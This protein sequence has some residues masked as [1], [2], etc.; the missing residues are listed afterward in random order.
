[1]SLI[2]RVFKKMMEQEVAVV[3]L[4]TVQHLITYCSV[5]LLDVCVW[6]KSKYIWHRVANTVLIET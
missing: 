5:A 4:I 1:M 6:N 2:F 3:K